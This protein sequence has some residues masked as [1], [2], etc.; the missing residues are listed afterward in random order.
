L[1]GNEGDGWPGSIRADEESRDMPVKSRPATME[2]DAGTVDVL[3]V[4]DDA[5][6][7]ESLVE[8]LA[9]EGFVAI[10]ATNGA[11]ALRLARDRKPGVILLDLEMPVMNGWQFLER[12]RSDRALMG[13]PVITLSALAAGTSGRRDV[14]GRLEKPLDQREL[15]DA[16]RPF[17][18]PARSAV[19]RPTILVV[20]DDDDTRMSVAELLEQE[21]YQV[22]RASHGEEA[23]A[24]L[25]HRQRPDCIVLDLMMPVMDGWTF[26]SRL[27]QMGVPP[28]PIVVITA[29]E[30]YWG[31]PVPPA[32]VVR[33]PIRPE[34]FLAM[35]RKLVPL[36]DRERRTAAAVA[37][38]PRSKHR[39]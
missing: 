18:S 28:I 9:Q 21:G 29:A 36:P 10:A 17:F 12:R 5:A 6:L 22:A 35:I 34:S 26:A 27:E 31:Y 30:P 1:K 3:V 24:Y 25:R 33:K 7:R 13:V 8:A 37:T 19:A 20:D 23:E 32:H 2:L 38:V 16:V 4:D 39:G 14:A 11:E 15:I